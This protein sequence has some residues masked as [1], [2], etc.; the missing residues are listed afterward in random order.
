MICLERGTTTVLLQTL[1]SF[2]TSPLPIALYSPCTPKAD[3]PLPCAAFANRYALGKAANVRHNGGRTTNDN[4]HTVGARFNPCVDISRRVCPLL[5]PDRN[6]CP[7]IAS[8]RPNFSEHS[9]VCGARL[10]HS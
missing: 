5:C 1:I 3:F 9:L 2:V 7:Y 6:D 4:C 8:R 10:R